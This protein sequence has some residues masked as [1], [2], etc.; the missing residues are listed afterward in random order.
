MS[1][2]FESI[3]TQIEDVLFQW[4]Q[5]ESEYIVVI[6]RLKAENERL[7]VELLELRQEL[8]FITK[9]FNECQSNE[10]KLHRTL[11]ELNNKIGM[12]KCNNR[13]RFFG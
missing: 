2:I 5:K 8:E 7:N 9:Q 6:D 13:W 1:G 10:T 11:D 12:N 4:N 3:R